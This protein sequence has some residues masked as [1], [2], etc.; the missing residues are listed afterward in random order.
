[1]FITY[2]DLSENWRINLAKPTDNE[3]IRLFKKTEKK[4]CKL[5][6]EDYDACDEVIDCMT[7]LG[8]GIGIDLSEE[9]EKEIIETL[10]EYGF[11][12]EE[13]MIYYIHELF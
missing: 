7:T 1:M 8:Q 13:A 2:K 4:L 11:S 10:K 5:E 3:I 9:E 6:D 12:K